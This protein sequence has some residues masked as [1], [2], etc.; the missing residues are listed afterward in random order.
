M[1]ESG[2]VGATFAVCDSSIEETAASASPVFVTA[3]VGSPM[4]TE[5]AVASPAYVMALFGMPVFETAACVYSVRNCNVCEFR[6]RGSSVRV[7]CS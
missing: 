3:V 5:A 1:C 4:C 7:K 2:P 6:N